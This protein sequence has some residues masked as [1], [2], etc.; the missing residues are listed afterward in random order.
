MPLVQTTPINIPAE[1]VERPHYAA[2]EVY[3]VTNELPT[4]LYDFEVGFLA[5]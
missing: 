5:I 4:P 1:K 2:F 3:V